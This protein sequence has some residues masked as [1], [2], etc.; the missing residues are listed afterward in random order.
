LLKGEIKI[1]ID[2]AL[3]KPSTK[4]IITSG[5]ARDN[6]SVLLTLA[7]LCHDGYIVRN[8][9]ERYHITNQGLNMLEELCPVYFSS[10]KEIYHR[11]TNGK[12][13]QAN[14]SIEM[15]AQLRREYITK[16]FSS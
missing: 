11:V 7:Q 6:L 16:V 13:K 8:K 10:N 3:K 2:I 5:V 14:R 4:Q 1:L 15:I 12:I 9:D